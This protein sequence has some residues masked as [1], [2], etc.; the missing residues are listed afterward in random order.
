M[1]VK[2]TQKSRKRTTKKSKSRR[3][4]VLR[5]EMENNELEYKVK[6]KGRINQSKSWFFGGKKNRQN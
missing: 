3:K 5:I 1:K 6:Q 2:Y 4:K